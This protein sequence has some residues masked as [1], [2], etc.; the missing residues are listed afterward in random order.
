[1][2]FPFRKPTASRFKRK[3]SPPGTP[4]P[5]TAEIE[6]LNRQRAYPAASPRSAGKLNTFRAALFSMPDLRSGLSTSNLSGMEIA[7]GSSGQRH[8]PPVHVTPS[9]SEGRPEQPPDTDDE[10]VDASPRR[11]QQPRRPEAPDFEDALT[12]LTQTVE[13]M[14]Q[15]VQRPG[16]QVADAPED[17]DFNWIALRSPLDAPFPLPPTGVVQRIA[18]GLYAKVNTNA[19][20]G[21][22]QRE[23]RFALDML[24]DWPDLDDDGRTRVF[25][26]V[27]IYAIVANHGWPTAIA[28]SSATTSNLACFLP[29]GVQPIVPQ[30]RQPNNQQGG[31]RRRNQ[32]PAADP[33][34]APV[35]APAAAPARGRGGGRNRR[36]N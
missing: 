9:S 11:R 32:R 4:G 8:P 23:A 5:H 30:Q 12:R 15:T 13:R 2:S 17:P 36:R 6:D 27:N 20:T 7:A 16:P 22:D 18:A 26:R 28:A 33:A 1:M 31:G 14:A 24:A 25:Q 35:A 19:I 34:P 21:R 3:R 10:Q 29:P